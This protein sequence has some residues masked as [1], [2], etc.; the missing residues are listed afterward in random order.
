MLKNYEYW[1]I[2]RE[3]S[4]EIVGNFQRLLK[5]ISVILINVTLEHKE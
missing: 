5:A 2:S 1:A 3:A 4:L